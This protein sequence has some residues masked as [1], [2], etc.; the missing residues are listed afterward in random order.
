MLCTQN[1]APSV[2]GLRADLGNR[3][4][5]S[6]K[7]NT[8]FTGNRTVT[9]DIGGEW[10]TGSGQVSWKGGVVAGN[11]AL[12]RTGALAFTDGVQATPVGLTVAVNRAELSQGALSVLGT[13]TQLSLDRVRAL[14]NSALMDWG[15]LALSGG[16][17]AARNSVLLGN[18][19][20]ENGG[21]IFAAGDGG[22]LTI[23]S[24]TFQ[25]DKSG[26]SGGGLSDQRYDVGI[27]GGTFAGN[28]SSTDGALAL[29]DHA[30]SIAAG[31]ERFLFLPTWR[32]MPGARCT[33]LSPRSF[34]PSAFPS[35]KFPQIRPMPAVAAVFSVEVQPPGKPCALPSR[36]TSLLGREEPSFSMRG[37]VISWMAAAWCKGTWPW[38]WLAECVRWRAP[39]AESKRF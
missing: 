2:G 30:D 25:G 13:S 20:G 39:V 5:L 22:R 11:S 7:K 18:R 27:T 31:G 17:L 4:S 23:Q 6:Q 3:T 32:K 26:I 21:A 38:Q 34:T 33:F 36:H 8:D 1:Y 28:F 35:S 12:E 29:T 16:D 14:G 19:A 24:T 9:S 15:A 10:F 37:R